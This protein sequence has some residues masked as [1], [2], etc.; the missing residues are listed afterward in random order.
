[1]QIA[2]KRQAPAVA[3][4]ETAKPAQDLQI[5]AVLQKMAAVA[6]TSPL[7]IVREYCSLA[8]GPGQV[9]FKEYMQLRL[10]DRD[11][12]PDKRTVVG[13]RK[14]RDLDLTINYRHDWIGLFANKIASASYLAA[15]GFPTIPVLGIYTENLASPSQ[16]VIAN[17]EALKA[18]LRRPEHYPMFGK[19]IEG[20]QSIGSI[21]LAQYDSGEDRLE[22]IGGE[23]ILVDDFASDVL[24]NFSQG[25]LFQK[26]LSPHPV[27]RE[28]CGNRLATA[29]IVTLA[30]D[31]EPS[32]FRACWKIPSGSNMADNYWRPGNLLAQIDVTTGKVLRAM[33]GTGLEFA[34][35]SEHPDTKAPLIGMTLPRWDDLKQTAIEA[36]RLLRH[37]P[38]IG[39][40]MAMS[41]TGPVVVEMNY[42]PDF[43]L[44]QLADGRGVLDA[45]FS[46]FVAEQK[47]K[48]AERTKMIK[49]EIRQ[50]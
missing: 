40:D 2:L 45:E 5:N 24:N 7:S 9:S 31:G 21:G 8:F 22:T 20:I 35:H 28:V 23:N 25:Y 10:F 27:I 17:A 26:F 12:Y 32:V 30:R 13:W 4:I 47:R 48:A 37:M 50:L 43:L 29:R 11:Y 46:A 44:N 36:A 34:C 42:N 3:T 1:M 19:P 39:F 38:L 15:H 6:A 14:N 33:S 16:H 18:F 49:R 41:E